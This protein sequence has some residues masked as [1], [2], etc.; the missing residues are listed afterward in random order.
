MKAVD[1]LPEGGGMWDNLAIAATAAG[2]PELAE[3]AD[4]RDLDAF[5]QRFRQLGVSTD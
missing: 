4:A 1:S 2:H 5:R 3:L